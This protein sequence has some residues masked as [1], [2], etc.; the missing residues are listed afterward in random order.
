MSISSATDARYQYVTEK[1][2]RNGFRSEEMGLHQVNPEGLKISFELEWN[3]FMAC[4]SKITGIPP[5]KDSTQSKSPWKQYF[6]HVINPASSGNRIIRMHENEHTFSDALF[7]TLRVSLTDFVDPNVFGRNCIVLK[8]SHIGFGKGMP[9]TNLG[10]GDHYLV[11]RDGRS[12]H[13]CFVFGSDANDIVDYDDDITAS[14]ELKQDTKMCLLFNKYTEPSRGEEEP[15]E[16][17]I[18]RGL[19]GQAMIFSWDVLHCLARRGVRVESVPV[20]LLAGKTE[21]IDDKK[22]CCLD[23]RIVIPSY[24][25][26]VFSCLFNRIVSFDGTVAGSYNAI[27]TSV[28]LAG[29][30]ARAVDSPEAT[31]FS[32]S[33]DELAIAIYIKTMRVGLEH[34]YSISKN[35]TDPNAL[36]PPRSICCHNLLNAN[37]EA[38]L[39]GS[40]IPNANHFRLSNIKVHQGE[41]FSVISPTKDDFSRDLFMK[42]F[43]GAKNDEVL[44][45]NCLVKVSHGSFHGTYVSREKCESA[46]GKLRDACDRKNHSALKQELAKVLL[47]YGH[48]AGPCLCMVMKDLRCED[49]ATLDHQKFRRDGKLPELWTAFCTLVKSLLLPMASED[50]AHVDIRSTSQITYNILCRVCS[51]STI[52]LRLIDYDSLTT[53]SNLYNDWEFPNQKDGIHFQDIGLYRMKSV[54]REG[55]ARRYVFWQVLWIA[56]TWHPKSASSLSLEA[57]PEELSAEDFLSYFSKENHAM[58]FKDWLGIDTVKALQSM[59]DEMISEATIAAALDMLGKAFYES[60]NR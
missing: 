20:A 57:A 24:V 37:V 6:Q 17:K 8:N 26:E 58:E 43:D 59:N 54:Q 2:S 30:D 48:Y 56:Y 60:H 39:V 40:S 5:P 12:Q 14:I 36:F 27:H 38:L 53:A 18:L 41:M 50:V 51:T 19:L 23:A 47:G 21:L 45:K 49:F 32:S 16:W 25:G 42:W 55:A 46:L 4:V 33:R 44:T 3:Q 52:E 1:L 9:R 11:S 22:V 15:R 10:F 28:D 34:A 35:R 7:E 13:G 29:D 31:V